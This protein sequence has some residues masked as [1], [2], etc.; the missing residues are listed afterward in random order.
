MLLDSTSLLNDTRQFVD[1]L[2]CVTANPFKGKDKCEKR[3]KQ[4]PRIQ[5]KSA[6]FTAMGTLPDLCPLQT[7]I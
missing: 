5:T 6:E 2:K 4:S 1:N 7:L 3:W